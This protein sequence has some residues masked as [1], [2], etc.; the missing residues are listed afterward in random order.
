MMRL[1]VRIGRISRLISTPGYSWCGR[2]KTTW[3]YVKPH[4]TWYNE[5]SAC[6][7]LCEKCWA[8]LTPEERMPYYERLLDYWELSSPVDPDDAEQ[9]RAAVL[10]G[11]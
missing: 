11:E 3:P 6:F 10:A 8:E 1:N 7:P 5:Y 4:R 2:C 9:I